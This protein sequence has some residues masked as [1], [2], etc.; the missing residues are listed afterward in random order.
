MYINKYS[1]E[2]MTKPT[3][4]PL[5]CKLELINPG[6]GRC[7]PPPIGQTP[8]STQGEGD[9][10]NQLQEFQQTEKYS[11]T[12]VYRISMVKDKEISYHD[13]V[14]QSRQGAELIRNTITACG[15]D[16]REQFI[17]IMFNSKNKVVGTNIVSMG[18]VDTVQVCLREVFKPAIMASA[19]AIIV[20]HNHPSGIL[21]PSQEDKLITKQIMTIAKFLNIKV[22]DHLI[23]DTIGDAYYSFCDEGDIGKLRSKVSLF[24]DRYNNLSHGWFGF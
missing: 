1:E 16:D 12:Y 18:S 6:G 4:M 2:Q 8:L 24:W 10:M 17:I 19:T 13:T 15:Q 20:G 22:H 5:E 11:V 14:S 23:V 9:V 3:K 21:E 7:S